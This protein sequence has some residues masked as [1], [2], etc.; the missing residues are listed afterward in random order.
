LDGCRQP[1]SSSE[2]ANLLPGPRLLKEEKMNPDPNR[3]GLMKLK[4]DREE[5]RK[6][7]NGLLI[8]FPSRKRVKIGSRLKKTS[9]TQRM[10][11]L[12]RRGYFYGLV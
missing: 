9:Q 1:F 8:M 5:A 3:H 4:I 10:P 7:R 2:S 11:E 12:I 6:A